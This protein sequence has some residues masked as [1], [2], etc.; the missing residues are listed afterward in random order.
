MVGYKFHFPLEMTD[1]EGGGK[2]QQYQK[3]DQKDV[4]KYRV[5]DVD[6]SWRY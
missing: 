3:K 2:R 5:D 1:R 6:M 4:C